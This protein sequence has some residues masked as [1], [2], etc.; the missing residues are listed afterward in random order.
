[1][2]SQSNS[3]IHP[4]K[5]LSFDELVDGLYF[6]AQ[7]GYINISEDFGLS[8]FNY[9]NKTTF[10]SNWNNFTRAARGLIL[11]KVNKKIIALP[12]QKFHNLHELN[13][14]L[15]QV[16]FSVYEKLD[17]SMIALWYHDNVWRTSTRGSF[18]SDQA[19]IAQKLVNKLPKYG[20]RKECTYL[21]ELVGPSNKIVVNYEEDE[22]IFLAAFNRETGEESLFWEVQYAAERMMCKAAKVF[23]YK[24]ISGMIQLAEN[25]SKDEEGFVVRFND[26][27]R[28]KIKGSEYLRIH[29][30][31]SKLSP[32][33]VWEMLKDSPMQIETMKKE[34][35]EELWADF[36]TIISILNS[37]TDEI[38]Q[39][40]SVF[41]TKTKH[42]SDKEIDLMLHQLPEDVRK[43]IFPLRKTNSPLE[44]RSREAIYRHI[45]P[46]GNRLEGYQPS[47]SMNRVQGELS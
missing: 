6:E 18:T 14:P 28:I 24:S 13:E 38:I 17:G 8:L 30:L 39:K 41:H 34:I 45:R 40:V 35:P 12:F 21:A 27:L 1:V 36:D 47:S 2:N 20:L 46:D 29:R 31:I 19:L 43:F 4:V 33:S 9:T 22:L 37:Q 26:G 23:P 15:P 11:D 3:I 32:L 44:G 42:L 5:L 16:P 25:L 10:D 7:N